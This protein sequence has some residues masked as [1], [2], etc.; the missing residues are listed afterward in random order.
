MTCDQSRS[1]AYTSAMDKQMPPFEA[2]PMA[3]NDDP[4]EALPVSADP[5]WQNLSVQAAAR[6]T[7]LD[8]QRK[9]CAAEGET[10]QPRIAGTFAR[11]SYQL[12]LMIAVGAG[13]Y[14]GI[15]YLLLSDLRLPAVS[16]SAA[17]L[18]ATP[19]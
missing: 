5:Y 6:L 10:E 7:R 2:S 16:G 15:T 9:L 3:A 11:R 4:G 13:L 19:R 12:A 1:V 8:E 14:A 17:T 18:T